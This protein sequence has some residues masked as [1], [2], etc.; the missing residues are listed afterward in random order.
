[1]T[2][3]TSFRPARQVSAR[4][5]S[6]RLWLLVRT[7]SFRLRL[8]RVRHMEV[9]AW[10]PG[11]T[12]T[13][14]CPTLELLSND[15]QGT[16]PPGHAN[17]PAGGTRRLPALTEAVTLHYSAAQPLTRHPVQPLRHANPIRSTQEPSTDDTYLLLDC[18][19]A[20]LIHTQESWV[21]HGRTQRRC[22]VPGIN[23]ASRTHGDHRLHH[24]AMP[25]N[26]S[27]Q[28][29]MWE[30]TSKLRRTVA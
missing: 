21:A 25:F 7:S 23:S 15:M 1:V 27:W 11:P 18:N 8:G 17:T 10:D 5:R 3:P 16:S 19:V 2:S 14:R 28:T 30:R 6:L 22:Q 9:G 20:G 29:S 24:S 26:A 13:W 4:T 12:R